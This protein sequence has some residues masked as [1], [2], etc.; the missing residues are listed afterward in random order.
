MKKFYT[1]F[2]IMMCCAASLSLS[3]TPVLSQR[4]SLSVAFENKMLI[5]VLDHLKGAT[6]MGFTYNKSQVDET[7][8]VDAQFSDASLEQVLGGVLAP[9]GLDYEIEGNVVFITPTRTVAAQQPARAQSIAA[10]GVVVNERG[11]V[12]TGAS[13]MIK[14]SSTG[15]A[16]DVQGRFA[17]TAPAGSTLVFMYVGH[18]TQERP[19]AANMRVVMQEATQQL[20][21]AVVTG[22]MSIDKRNFTGTSTQVSREEI[23]SVNA[24]NL[25]SALQ[26][27][28]PS[29]RIAVNNEMGSDPN[30]LPEFY[31]R[32]RSGLSGV[33]ELDKIQA[34]ESGTI[35]QYGLQNNTNL[36]LFILDG[37]QVTYQTIYDMDI[38]RIESV[39]ILKDAAATAF[40]GSRASNGIVVI[41]T[42]A[43]QAGQL[44]VSYNFNASVTAPDLS[45]YNLAN[46]KEHLEADVA[47]GL[48]DFNNPREGN[49]KTYY[50]RLEY[51]NHLLS[52]IAQG[53]DTYWLSQP[54]QTQFNHRHSLYIEG[55]ENTVRF[56]VGVNFDSSNGVM[57]ESFRRRLGADFKIDY[58]LKSA[59]QV[60]NMV[61]FGLTN[62]QDSPYGSFSS[63]SDKLPYF[64]PWD[65]TTGELR[66][67][68]ETPH[69]AYSGSTP[70][71][72]YEA[73]VGNFSRGR[74]GSIRDNLTIDAFFLK[75]FRFRTTASLGYSVDSSRKFV[76]PT[77]VT[78][79]MQI[80]TD[81][82][83]LGS[84][85]TGRTETFNWEIN[86]L[87]SFN[88]NI[89]AHS[90]NAT[91]GV[92]ASEN[93]ARSEYVEYRGF[94]SPSMAEEK[95]AKKITGDKPSAFTNS[96][97]LFGAYL[98]ANY[99]WN[100]IY[101]ADLSVRT[102]GSSDVGVDQHFATF[103]AAGAGINFHNYQFAKQLK[104]LDRARITANY[105][106]TGKN[107]LPESA[108]RHTYQMILDQWYPTGIGSTLNAMGN[109]DLKW[110]SS[111]KFNIGGDVRVL[112]RVGAGFNWYDT[113]TDN[114]ISAMTI[115]SSTGFTSYYENVGKVM[116][117]GWELTLDGS[118]IKNRDWNLNVIVRAGHNTN[119]IIEISDAM[120]EYNDRVAAYYATMND[121]GG[122][123][124]DPKYSRPITMY[125]EGGSESSIFGMKSLGISP[126]TGKELFVR[127]DGTVTYE[128]DA[129]EQ[130]IIGNI[131]P[132]VNG[133]FAFNLRW[134]NW[135]LYT[136]FLYN[137]GGDAYNSTLVNLVENVDVWG[138]NVDRRVVTDRWRK[139]GDVASLKNI[140]DRY[141]T[142]RPTSRFVQKDNNLSFNSLSLTYEMTPGL[143][144]R[145]GMSRISISGSMN[146]VAYMSTI[147][148]ERG[149]AYPYARTFNLSLNA[150][151]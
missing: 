46:A 71:P 32:G 140:A 87:L 107:S 63:Y 39:T 106:L 5:E 135:T 126:A 103:W 122:N 95:Y 108:S 102:D 76:S 50:E 127:R 47:A 111:K 142:T 20:G 16:A 28:D 143:V 22:L 15:V 40:Y 141:N 151:F 44:R 119:K 133:S 64:S 112:D 34:S 62:S 113:R 81:L 120:R 115:P 37:S 147:K 69:V 56:G 74:N 144:R 92:N 33:T 48:I 131:E 57:K 137:F 83:E 128:W 10:S 55:G 138:R 43:P 101:L 86:S 27:F 60:T 145:L 31:V 26:V 129:A 125:V 84:L 61:S 98:S 8:R 94:T 3:A 12:M 88:K 78:Q 105:G 45:A 146:D 21:E 14:G 18:K 110:E 148:R 19:A 100:D 35:S 96:S 6:G 29:L 25:V 134:R 65:L 7:A 90:I 75:N 54:L 123:A 11:E 66:K 130:Q 4:A 73:T 82:F 116:N 49:L 36:P 150:S 24:N 52:N 30:T 124:Q 77:S 99:T 118:I 139:P 13:V 136:S 85:N 121:F 53:V 104:W 59:L 93:S 117:R 79:T 51:Y 67:E 42:V 23:K 89:S 109:P 72:L 1:R 114:L 58:R 97:R 70:N 17:I 132:R 149:L 68:L 9:R 38:N 41:E 91:V 2:L 80:D